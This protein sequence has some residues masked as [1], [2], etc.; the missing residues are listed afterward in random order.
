MKDRSRE[1]A[2]MPEYYMDK[3]DVEYRMRTIK[4]TCDIFDELLS[5]D[6]GDDYWKRCVCEASILYLEQDM[7]DEETQQ[8]PEEISLCQAQIDVITYRLK[9]YQD[10]KPKVINASK[11]NEMLNITLE[12][13]MDGER[14]EN[15]SRESLHYLCGSFR[16]LLF[17]SCPTAYSVDYNKFK[18]F[19]KRQGISEYAD[20]VVALYTLVE[21][22]QKY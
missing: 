2:L 9:P 14:V 7:Y 5:Y 3:Y 22:Y 13:F 1:I 10:V 11:V 21:Q 19:V 4:D 17:K 12:N 16:F 8:R 15:M 20:R 6:T 18:E